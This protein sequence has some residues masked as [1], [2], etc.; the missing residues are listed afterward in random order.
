MAD[1]I[2]EMKHITKKFPGVVALD[3]VSFSVETG[4]VHA[5]VGEN[6][7]GKST[8]MKILNGVYFAD[9]G[10]ILINGRGVELGDPLHAQ[11][12][13]ISII[14]QEFNLVS[15][16]SV[17]ENIFIGRLGF[18]KKAVDWKTLNQKAK[19]LLDKLNYQL[20]PTE[21]VSNLTVAQMQMIEIAKAL[22]FDSKI[23]I[24]DEPSSVLTDNELEK[25]FSI[26]R[27]L[28]KD[29]ITVIYI[30][31]RLEEVFKI[32][33]KVTVLRDGK[34]IDTKPVSELSR[35]QIIEKMVGRKMDQEFPKRESAIG[36][37]VMS[38][39]N[40]NRG[41]MVRDISFDLRK[42]EILGIA[43]LV[44]AGR[45][46]VARAIFGADKKE[47]GTIEI[48]GKVQNIDSP[49]DA[50]SCG[51]AL[52]PEDRKLHGL[53]LEMPITYNI[54]LTN[55]LKVKSKFGTLTNRKERSHAESFRASLQ[56]KTPSVTQRVKFLSGGNQQKVVI[57][58]WLFSDVDILIMD[59]PTR[60]IDV[61]A[62]YEIYLLMNRLVQQGKSV[63]LISSELNEIIALSDRVL[64]MRQGKINASFEKEDITAER[65][66]KAAIG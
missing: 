59:E 37:V 58:K 21:I 13:G 8:L 31:H 42:G 35:E 20:D 63:I 54:S 48:H 39:K 61:G 25:L 34:V 3:D 57:A 50:K 38:V 19:E 41:K 2:L 44:G 43:G 22:S 4:D 52:M 26:I 47:T 7:A 62:K 45:T 66:L 55:F 9:L 29:G 10:D 56:I 30:S 5:L 14:F 28:K 51:I 46:E 36:E 1:F 24:M 33:D 40:L 11:K 17:A 15:M 32:C 53:L 60:G 65:V 16:L 18:G 64:V 27:N 23:I 49:Y 6:G 12:E